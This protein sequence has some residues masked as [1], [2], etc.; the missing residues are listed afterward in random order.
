MEGV[1]VDR[2]RRRQRAPEAVSQA[3][4]V[5]R[6]TAAGP[7]AVTLALVL[8]ILLVPIAEEPVH[9]AQYLCHTRS[10]D[11][12]CDGCNRHLTT[13]PELTNTLAP[14]GED[15]FLPAGS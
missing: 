13:L 10:Q 6:R 11:Q 12:D 3:L 2:A 8:G 5:G 14:P 1:L 7:G 15:G 4:G 9:G